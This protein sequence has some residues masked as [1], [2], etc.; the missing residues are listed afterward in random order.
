[1][2]KQEAAE[3]TSDTQRNVRGEN[4]IDKKGNNQALRSGDTKEH[5]T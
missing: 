4:I 5:H 3:S 1:M 2:W